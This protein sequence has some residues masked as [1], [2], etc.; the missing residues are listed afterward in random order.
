MAKH[1]PLTLL[2]VLLSCAGAVQ[3]RG[4]GGQERAQ[5]RPQPQP[6]N[7]YTSSGVDRE[8]EFPGGDCAMVRYINRERR[9]P[10]K[11]Y[12]EGVE[13]RVLCQFIVMEDGS[14]SHVS[15]VRGVEQTLD[16][17]AVRVI[18]QMPR[19][20]AGQVGGQRVPVMCFLPIAFRR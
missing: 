16:R 12:R 9:Y 2:L 18:S 5:L 14:I 4:R 7:V 3:A 8:P 1:L 15:V 11:A 6:V 17:E 13:G 10:A 19:W 20:D